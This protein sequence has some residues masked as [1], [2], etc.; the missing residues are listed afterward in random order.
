LDDG[1]NDIAH[2]I[3]ALP[4]TWPE[5]RRAFETVKGIM[6]SRPNPKNARADDRN[7]IV[8]GWLTDDEAKRPTKIA[9]DDLR[10]DV[11]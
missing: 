5:L 7:L 8:K 10:S 3:S 6:S 4:M 9:T 11:V 1:V 2:A